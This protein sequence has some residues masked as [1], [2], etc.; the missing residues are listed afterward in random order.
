MEKIL[1][2]FVKNNKLLIFVT[3]ILLI[4][5]TITVINYLNIKNTNKQN[6]NE[7]YSLTKFNN[8]EDLLLLWIL[9]EKIDSNYF[10]N[11]WWIE[12]IEFINNKFNIFFPKWSY[13]PENNPR[14]WAWFIYKLWNEYEH[15]KLS[16]KIKFDENFDF[17]KWWKLPWFCSWDC[18]RW[19]A[20]VDNWFST[21]FMWRKDWDIEIYAYI[22]EKNT[23]MWKSIARWFFRFKKWIE[24]E[25]SQEIK[26]NKAWINNWLLVIYV[27]WKNIYSN[28]EMNFRNK[29]N[30]K[31][32]SLL[33]STF[34]WWSD[35]SWATPIDTNIE[36]SDFKI[37]Y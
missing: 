22:P 6:K 1:K 35:S 5:Y 33:F 12:N 14:W 18:P 28:N 8:K 15:A 24:Y 21:R 7:S 3:F 26:L 29:E 9:D 10:S 25:I 31:I 37:E 13:N 32:D 2:K 20:E 34:F 4:I 16:Y 30:L 17:V 27:N 11:Y 19:W 36:F 23:T